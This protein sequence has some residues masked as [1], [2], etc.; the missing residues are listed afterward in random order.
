MMLPQPCP[1]I[2]SPLFHPQSALESLQGAGLHPQGL[3]P[4][5]WLHFPW[6]QSMESWIYSFS[7]PWEAKP[8]MC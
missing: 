6:I 7:L 3:N 2:S 4:K 8:S 5:A 1:V